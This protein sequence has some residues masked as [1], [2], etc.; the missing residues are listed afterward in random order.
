MRRTLILAFLELRTSWRRPSWW[1]LLAILFFLTWGFSSGSV[2]IGAGGSQAGGDR[3][4]VN[5]EFNLAFGDIVVFSLFYMF[6]VCT[7][8]GN[9]VNED[10]TLRVMP[11]VGSTGITPREYVIGRWLGIALVFGVVMALHLA[12]QIGFFQLYPLPEPEKMRG[13]FILANYLRPMVV[14]VA[15]PALSLGAIA[16]AIGSITRQTVLVFALP[17]ALLLSSL[18][19]IWLFSPDGC[20]TGATARCKPWTSLASAGSTRR[21]S[22]W[23]RAWRS[24]TTSRSASTPCS[25]ARVW[26]WWRLPVQRSS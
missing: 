9:A 8:F 4:F 24:T 25:L 11:I 12:M 14:F 15:I 23:T 26:C 20:R 6:F 22:R 5:S 17:V 21:G 2:T 13:P 3:A 19:F 18:F 1:V 10:D 7:T 16:F